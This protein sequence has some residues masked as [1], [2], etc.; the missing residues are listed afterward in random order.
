MSN[1]TERTRALLIARREELTA[2]IEELDKSTRHRD[3]PLPADFEEQATALEDREV[4]EALGDES[5]DELRQVNRAL[6]RLEHGSYGTCE[7]CGTEIGTGRL[8]AL[9]FA[10][11]CI[12]CAA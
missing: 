1:D 8:T 4:Q 5:R 10:T 7:K 12:R 6:D 9:P 2:R 3:E 11:L